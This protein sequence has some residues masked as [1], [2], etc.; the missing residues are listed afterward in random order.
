MSR[1]AKVFE[2]R[3][4]GAFFDLYEPDIVPSI[5]CDGIV[6]VLYGA[7]SVTLELYKTLPSRQVPIDPSR[8]VSV[9]SSEIPEPRE[10]V[11]KVTFPAHVF[12][13]MVG[14][15]SKQIRENRAPAE[16]RTAAF[17]NA[18]TQALNAI[19]KGSEK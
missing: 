9:G 12:Y 15:V 19:E 10:V 2:S 17:T 14:N 18:I 1:P 8:P 7:A 11:G 3:R 4:P 16:L 13:G 6:N 5:D